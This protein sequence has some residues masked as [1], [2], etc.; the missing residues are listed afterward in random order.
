M[1]TQLLEAKPGERIGFFDGIYRM[2]GG[3][4]IW[5]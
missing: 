2:G 4:W 1:K 3:R 5:E